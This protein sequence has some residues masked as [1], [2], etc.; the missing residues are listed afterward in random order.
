MFTVNLKRKQKKM[1]R[2]Y[3]VTVIE[4]LT[5]KCVIVAYTI[6]PGL[7]TGFFLSLP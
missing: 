4:K 2:I 1:L 6:H 3:I 7:K 5:R